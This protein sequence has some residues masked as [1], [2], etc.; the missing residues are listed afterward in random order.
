M[1][2][3]TMAHIAP[4]RSAAYQ[5]PGQE[6]KLPLLP[7]DGEQGVFMS[8]AAPAEPHE[9]D[10]RLVFRV[11]EILPFRMVGPEGHYH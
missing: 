8:A 7:Q 6:E 2:V 5:E 10:A 9:F 3:V 4:G 1:L 11:E